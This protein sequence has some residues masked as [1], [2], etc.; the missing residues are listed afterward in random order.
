MDDEVISSYAEVIEG[1]CLSFL[2]N[3]T[4]EPVLTCYFMDTDDMRYHSVKLTVGDR[5]LNR[6]HFLEYASTEEF[7]LKAADMENEM[8]QMADNEEGQQGAVY[9][10]EA[11]IEEEMPVYINQGYDNEPSP[12]TEIEGNNLS[13]SYI[14]Y[15]T[16]DDALE[17]LNSDMYVSKGIWENHIFHLRK[18]YY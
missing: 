16:E 2:L 15:G 1:G 3:F 9:E 13:I 10:P 4:P 5:E 17:K 8:N 14:E 11:D 7:K 12:E 18:K 6:K